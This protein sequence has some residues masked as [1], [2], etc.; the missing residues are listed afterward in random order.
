MPPVGVEVTIQLPHVWGD[1]QSPELVGKT[2]SSGQ[3]RNGAGEREK[4]SRKLITGHISCRA[5][6]ASYL[7]GDGCL[8]G[9]SLVHADEGYIVVQVIDRALQRE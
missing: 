2:E 5:M 8:L 9:H 3:G 4:R 1:I 7:H 6:C